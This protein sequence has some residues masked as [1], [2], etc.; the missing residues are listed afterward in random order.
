MSV[1][2]TSC[3]VRVPRQSSGHPVYASYSRGGTCD[4]ARVHIC[5]PPAMPPGLLPPH[6]MCP[7]FLDSAQGARRFDRTTRATCRAVA[8][9]ATSSCRSSLAAPP[10]R[11]PEV[12]MLA[13]ATTAPVRPRTPSRVPPH[14]SRP[15]RVPCLKKRRDK[16]RVSST[17][18][19]AS[20]RKR[21]M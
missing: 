12:A 11:R 13:E 3:K 18:K 20:L 1:R 5:A 7:S 15:T 6:R 19:A 14:P 10:E 8:S 16:R 2:F 9:P 17:H 4:G 21:S